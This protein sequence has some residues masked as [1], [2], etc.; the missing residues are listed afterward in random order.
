MQI[1]AVNTET[2]HTQEMYVLRHTRVA[3]TEKKQKADGIKETR[4]AVKSNQNLINS[5]QKNAKQNGI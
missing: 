3:A 5:Q 2:D 1:N 4:E